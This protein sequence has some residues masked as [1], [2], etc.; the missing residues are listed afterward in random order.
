[1]IE[2]LEAML[3]GWGRS[4]Y[5]CLFMVRR[6]SP[7]AEKTSKE[8]LGAAGDENFRCHSS[9]ESKVGH[10]AQLYPRHNRGTVRKYAERH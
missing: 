4:N 2:G 6:R 3:S 5:I 7:Y 10:D 8:G 1:M 9:K